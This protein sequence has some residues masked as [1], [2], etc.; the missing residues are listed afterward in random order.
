M[1]IRACGRKLYSNKFTWFF[2]KTKICRMCLIT[3]GECIYGCL[4]FIAVWSCMH[5]KRQNSHTPWLSQ[6]KTNKLSG[7]AEK[8]PYKFPLITI[9]AIPLY[10]PHN[11]GSLKLQRAVVLF[12][13][14]YYNGSCPII[15]MIMI[16]CFLNTI[17]YDFI[18][19][20]YQKVYKNTPTDKLAY[21]I[22]THPCKWIGVF[23]FN[24]PTLSSRRV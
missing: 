19:T 9:L 6:P 11:F 2:H 12:N 14:N 18:H 10:N 22:R 3:S 13:T 4:L 5:W 7:V 23:F 16:I 15:F 1:K 21:R 20:V 17:F 24:Q 8:N